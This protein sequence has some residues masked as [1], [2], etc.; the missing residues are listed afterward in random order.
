MKKRYVF[1]TAQQEHAYVLGATRRP[2]PVI[3][4]WHPITPNTVDPQILACAPGSYAVSGETV[5]IVRKQE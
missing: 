5:F 3:L 2:K 1:L 4:T